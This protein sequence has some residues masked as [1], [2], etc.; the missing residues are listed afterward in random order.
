M[1]NRTEQNRIFTKNRDAQFDSALDDLAQRIRDQKE[2]EAVGR[3]KEKLMHAGMCL[4]YIN[5]VALAEHDGKQL[6]YSTNYD[7]YGLAKLLKL[8]AEMK[9][10]ELKDSKIPNTA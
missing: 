7:Q 10:D 9:R 3:A 2:L 6:D 1:K 8:Q 5:V 4:D